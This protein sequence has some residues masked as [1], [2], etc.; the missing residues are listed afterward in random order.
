MMDGEGGEWKRAHRTPRR[1]LFTPHRVA[2]GPGRDAVM[3]TKRISKGTFVRSRKEFTIIDDY[4][5]PD[6]THRILANAWIGITIIHKEKKKEDPVDVQ[7]VPNKRAVWADMYSD[8]DERDERERPTRHR[9][10]VQSLMSLSER[11]GSGCGI[12][13]RLVQQSARPYY[14]GGVGRIN[15]SVSKEAQALWLSS[16]VLWLIHMTAVLRD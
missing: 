16:S 4:A 5:D 3:I 13:R 12:P 7:V 6:C 1:A 11:R 10:N 9:S 8:S 2:G 15:G 14:L